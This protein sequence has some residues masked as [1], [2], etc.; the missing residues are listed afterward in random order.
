MLGMDFVKANRAEVERAIEVKGVD[1]D[2]DAL[3]TLDTEVRALKTAI[4]ALRAERNA[5]SARF[6]DS[7][8]EEKAE[9]GRQAKDAG[10]RASA[11][12]GELEGK[13]AALKSLLL[14]LPGISRVRRSDPTRAPTWSSVRLAICR[15]SASSR[16]T[17][18][19]S[20]RRTT[21]AICRG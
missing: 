8:P 14:R 10:A 6:K 13:D 19:R 15:S 1:L 17:M 2:L 12:E 21:G 18:W 20:S 5:L 7:T 11:L 9:L 4:E 3:L 16:S